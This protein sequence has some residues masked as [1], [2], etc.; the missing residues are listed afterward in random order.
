LPNTLQSIAETTD[1]VVMVISHT[2]FSVIG[3]QFHPEAILT[4][5]GLQL[6]DNWASFA[7][8]K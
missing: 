8:L 1:G 4:P 6:L 3:I 7:L 2:Y 5:N